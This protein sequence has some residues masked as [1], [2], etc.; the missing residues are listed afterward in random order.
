MSRVGREGLHACDEHGNII[1]VG[2][3]PEFVKESIAGFLQ[4]AVGCVEQAQE[5][6]EA[7]V[8]GVMTNLDE[9]VGIQDQSITRA[10]GEGRGY[11]GDAADPK[12]GAGRQVEQFRVLAATD[13]GGGA[14]GLRWRC[15][16]PRGEGRRRR[17]RRWL[18]TDPVLR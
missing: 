2:G 18:C 15:G 6:I 12:R 3:E 9:A 13:Q 16:T 11:E 8:D 7:F 1:R 17:R 5:G 10:D 4:G 14:D